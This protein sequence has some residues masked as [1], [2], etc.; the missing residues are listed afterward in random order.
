MKKKIR[1]MGLIV[2]TGIMI[3]FM[4][5]GGVPK[6]TAAAC[7]TVT[8]ANSH[9]IKGKYPQQFELAEFEKLTKCKLSFAENPEISKLNQEIAGNLPLKTAKDRLPAEPLIWAPYREIGKYGGTFRGLS[10][11]TEAGTAEMLSVRHVHFIRYLDDLKTIVPNVAKGWTWNKDY[12][13]LTL[14][15]RKGHK[16][17]DGQPFTS[18]DVLFWYND[19][20]LNQEIYKKTPSN[21]LFDG[22]P[23]VMEAPD[24][25]TVIMKFGK[26]TPGMLNRLAVHFGQTFLPKHFL[27]KFH[28]KYNPQADELAKQKGLKNWAELFAKYY[29]LS[30]WKDVPSPLLDNF[31]TVVMPTLESHILVEETSKGRVLVANPYFH[32]VDTAGNQLPYISRIE[33]RYIPDKE[34]RNLKLA[35]GEVDFKQQSIYLDDYPFYKE[36]EKKGN[37]RAEMVPTIGQMIYYAFN[38]TSKDPKKRQVFRDVRFRQAMSVALDRNEIKEIVYLGVGRPEQGLPADPVSCPFVTAQHRNAF[39]Q[40]DIK[41]ANKLLDEMKLVDKN[42]DGLRDFP[43]GSPLVIQL[44]YA[45]QGGPIRIHELAAGYWHQIGI[46]VDLKEVTTNEYRTMVSNNDADVA[47]WYNILTTSV[48]L[49]EEPQQFFPPF[50]GTTNPGIGFPWASWKASQGKEGLEPPEDVKKLFTLAEKF[51]QVPFGSKESN[52]IGREVV[53]IHVKNLWKIGIM[54]E[55]SS[56]IIIHNRLG[57]VPQLTSWSTDHYR[58]YPFRSSQWYIKQ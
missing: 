13:V 53:D 15:L 41:L 5:V 7:A 34:I 24:D 16:W 9:G 4:S 19:V 14:K 23:V 21:W 11:A 2:F 25:N 29:K 46:R 48:R 30:D 57:N 20:I 36:N 35:N 6:A 1:Y 27:G 56:P 26:P 39:I 55:V 40:H 50:G 32:I 54:G 8:V 38:A 18:A 33:E 42:G 17:S 52:V 12:T 47:S 3:V 22:K 37:Y 43:D 45:T 51:I 31:D 10:E 44:Q 49:S 58:T 28:I